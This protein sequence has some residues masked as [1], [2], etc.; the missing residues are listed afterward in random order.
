MGQGTTPANSPGALARLR[1]T[2]KERPWAIKPSG[3]ECLH[4]F[5]VKHAYVR[6]IDGRLCGIRTRDLSAV[7]CFSPPH[8]TGGLE[9]R[10]IYSMPLREGC[11][12]IRHKH[13]R[14]PSRLRYVRVCAPSVRLRAVC[15]VTDS[16]GT[17]RACGTTGFRSPELCG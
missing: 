2:H 11:I 5:V 10:K 8:F 4:C 9:L 17:G 1:H 7:R 6:A 15:S 13:T 14:V 12:L 16:R 3:P